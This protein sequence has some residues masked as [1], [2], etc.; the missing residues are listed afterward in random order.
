MP[1]DLLELRDLD[2]Q[3]RVARLGLF[4]DALE[5]PLNVVA[6]GD[7][8]LELQRLEVRRR[9]ARPRPAVEDGKQRVVLP[10]VP[11]QR[12]SGSRYVDDPHRRRR[13]LLGV[14]DVR[15]PAEAC[16]GDLRHADV[17]LAGDARLRA[18]QR[19]KERGRPC[20]G[21]TD[22]ADLHSHVPSLGAGCG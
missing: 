18:R 17:L 12:C 8:Q 5:P 22:D 15:E 9:I 10:Q 16:I 6:V 1:E 2:P 13:H 4:G 20:V 3:L 21:K 11:E 19:P 7:E 14:D